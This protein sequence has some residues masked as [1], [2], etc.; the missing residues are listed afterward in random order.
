MISSFRSS[1]PEQV[2]G[3]LQCFH[4]VRTALCGEDLELCTKRGSNLEIEQ[5]QFFG[6]GDIEVSHRCAQQASPI[7]SKA[8]AHWSMR[9]SWAKEHG[10]LES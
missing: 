7:T 9:K 5:H 1:A 3:L 8:M 4:H 6:S 10:L 2:E